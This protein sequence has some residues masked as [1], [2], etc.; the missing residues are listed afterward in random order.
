MSRSGV[1]VT[2]NWETQ[3]MENIAL[4]HR[5]NV[6]TDYL[7]SFGNIDIDWEL[8]VN[9]KVNKYIVTNLGTHIIYDD[10]ILFDPIRNDAG[11][12]ISEGRPKLQFKQLLGVGVAY[13]F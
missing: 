11:V 8:N 5:L 12:V 4:K 13:N 3:L 7:R 1:L 6:Y 2:N 10:D 9:L